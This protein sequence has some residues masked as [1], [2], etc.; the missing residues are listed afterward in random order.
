MPVGGTRRRW[1]DAAAVVSVGGS[2]GSGN[3]VFSCGL[4]GLLGIMIGAALCIGIG[5]CDENFHLLG[6]GDCG[7]EGLHILGLLLKVGLMT[8]MFQN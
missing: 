1:I 2:G 5:G 3:V 7:G 4:D 6:S 8:Q